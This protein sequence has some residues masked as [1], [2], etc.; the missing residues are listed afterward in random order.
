MVKFTQK[1]AVID[2]K[3]I[4]FVET[5]I[6]LGGYSYSVRFDERNKKKINSYCRSLGFI[7][8]EVADDIDVPCKVVEK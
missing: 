2:G 6:C 1:T 7:I 3:K 8:G 4:A 5:V